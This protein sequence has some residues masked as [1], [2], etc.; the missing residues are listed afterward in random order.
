[1]KC[2]DCGSEDQVTE[3]DL[4]RG[5][6]SIHGMLCR[7]CVT[8]KLL[9]LTFPANIQTLEYFVQFMW[10]N[11]P[12]EYQEREALLKSLTPEQLGKTKEEQTFRYALLLLLGDVA[13]QL[14]TSAYSHRS[15]LK[16]QEQRVNAARQAQ[17]PQEQPKGPRPVPSPKGRQGN[18]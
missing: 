4:Q 6:R 15:L 11:F 18:D 3:F 16:I 12:M 8:E 5:L 1:M 13:G 9:T 7:K 14:Q 2:T 17:A 10:R